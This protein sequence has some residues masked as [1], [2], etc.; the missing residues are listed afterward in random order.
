MGTTALENIFVCGVCVLS[1]VQLFATVS[2]ARTTGVGCHFLLQ[3]IFLTQGAKSCLLHLLHRQADS[4]PFVL[5]EPQR[6]SLYVT[7]SVY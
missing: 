1:Q 2:Q 4:L 5:W 7:I 6:T 3:G